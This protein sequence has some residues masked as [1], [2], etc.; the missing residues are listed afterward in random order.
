MS[1]SCSP[2]FPASLQL[3]M[4][5]A[6]SQPLIRVFQKK[7]KLADVRISHFIGSDLRPDM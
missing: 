5:S 4:L 2:R 7:T 1:A 6:D 3:N